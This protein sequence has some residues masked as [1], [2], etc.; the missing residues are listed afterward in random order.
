[1]TNRSTCSRVIAS[2]RSAWLST[3]ACHSRCPEAVVEP[4]RHVT[5]PTGPRPGWHEDE[6]TSRISRPRPSPGRCEPEA[7]AVLG[8][9]PNHEGLGPG[10]RWCRIRSHAKSYVEIARDS[11]SELD[12]SSVWRTVERYEISRASPPEVLRIVDDLGVMTMRSGPNRGP[13]VQLSS[14]ETSVACQR[15]TRRPR[16]GAPRARHARIEF[17]PML[18]RMSVQRGD[19]VYRQRLLAMVPYELSRGR[20]G[21]R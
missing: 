4:S 5:S 9:I 7:I 13:L 1:M 8:S 12:I 11:C 15:A 21:T 17:E 18:A 2:A 16:R 6:P 14:P 20:N 10:T 19:P 3:I